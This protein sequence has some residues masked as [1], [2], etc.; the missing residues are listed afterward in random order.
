[1][2]YLHGGSPAPQAKQ[3]F[4]NDRIDVD[5]TWRLLWWDDRYRDGTIPR[6]E[7]EYAFLRP[8]VT[9]QSVA[10]DTSAS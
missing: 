4:G 5:V 6:E 8:S 3:K 7:Q 1:M 2:N 10:N 9:P